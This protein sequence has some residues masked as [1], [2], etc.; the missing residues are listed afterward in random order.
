MEVFMRLIDY[1][2]ALVLVICFGALVYN[3][4]YNEASDSPT[5]GLFWIDNNR[6]HSDSI[7]DCSPIYDDN[8]EIIGEWIR[9]TYGDSIIHIECLDT[10]DNSY[11]EFRDS[12]I[13]AFKE[14]STWK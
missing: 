11:Q 3:I 1:L 8:L 12:W 6:V 2:V 10:N 9:V 4:G 14:G 13:M 7:I 5:S